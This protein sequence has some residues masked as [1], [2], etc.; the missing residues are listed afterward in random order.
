MFIRI[1][2]KGI[3]FLSNR[4]GYSYGIIREIQRCFNGFS[5]RATEHVLPRNGTNPA[6]PEISLARKKSQKQTRTHDELV[7]LPPTIVC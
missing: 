4:F 6:S 3:T 5:V 7:S 2:I 1:T